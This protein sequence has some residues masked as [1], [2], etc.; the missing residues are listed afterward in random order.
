MIGRVFVSEDMAVRLP[1]SQASPR[2]INLINRGGLAE[3][4]QAAYDDGVTA[5]IR[6]G[7]RRT[8][9]LT[10]KLVRVRFL[11]PRRAGTSV[12]VGLRWEATGPAAGLFPVLDADIALAPSGEQESRLTLSGTY[13]PPLGRLGEELDRAM[14]GRV[15]AATVRALL[16][17]V[18]D[19]LARPEPHSQPGVITD[20]TRRPASEHGT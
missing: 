10:A 3:A 20:V 18:S 12:R 15:A 5:L 8:A 4:S 11:E 9:P 2:L 13:R 17:D 14:L 16:E 19:A 6:V 7:P 1:F